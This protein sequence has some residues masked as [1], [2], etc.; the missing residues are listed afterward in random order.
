MGTNIDTYLPPIV[1]PGC[2]PNMLNPAPCPAEGE[3]SLDTIFDIVQTPTIG[4]IVGLVLYF[5]FKKQQTVQ[6]PMPWAFGSGVLASALYGAY[7]F[8]L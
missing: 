2:G 6:R 5:Q 7:K 1:E 8:L 4:L 3:L